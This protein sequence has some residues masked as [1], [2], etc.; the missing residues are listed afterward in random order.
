MLHLFRLFAPGKTQAVGDADTVG[1]ADHAAGNGVQVAQKEIGGFS[2]H[3]GQAQKL[4]HSAGDFA[5]IVCQQHLA[6]EDN[7]F[8]F[9]PEKT[10]GTDV[11][12]HILHLGGGHSF[13]G[14]IGGKKGGGDQIDP[15]VRA[16]G[17]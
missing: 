8:R 2:A 5:A 12:F 3:A 10:A 6:G 4:L 14:G 1:I 9:L 15:G 17:G 16:L 7:V 11:I 13:Q